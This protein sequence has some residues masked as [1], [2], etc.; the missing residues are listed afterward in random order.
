MQRN[1]SPALM[2]TPRVQPTTKFDRQSA[3]IFGLTRHRLQPWLTQSHIP[4]VQNMFRLFDETDSC[5]RTHLH[6][7]LDRVDR[8]ER[9]A[10]HAAAVVLPLA[11]RTAS[12]SASPKAVPP[13]SSSTPELDAVS[14]KRGVAGGERATDDRVLYPL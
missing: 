1:I 10:R 13:S 14:P 2:L 6:R 8:R 9:N 7:R 4:T 5:E 12:G 3:R 11:V